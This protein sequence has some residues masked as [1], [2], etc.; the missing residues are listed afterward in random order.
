MSPICTAP[1]GPASSLRCVP[2]STRVR[3]ST[4][5]L[6]FIP[7]EVLDAQGR[8]VSDAGIELT[9]ASDGEAHVQA[10]GSANPIDAASVIDAKATSFR[11]RALLILRSTGKAGKARVQLSTP[12]LQ[13]TT[14]TVEFLP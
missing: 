7:I 3:A 1:S 13:S 4:E 12:G 8:L 5:S 14:T 9:A 11:G 10:F 2:E 6:V